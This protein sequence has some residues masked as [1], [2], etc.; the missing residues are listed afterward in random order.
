MEKFAVIMQSDKGQRIIRNN[1]VLKLLPEKLARHFLALLSVQKAGTITDIRSGETLGYL[2]DMPGFLSGLKKKKEGNRRKI[3]RSL[4]QKLKALNVSILCFSDI[5]DYFYEDECLLLEEQGITL[6]DGFLNRVAGLLLVFNRLLIILEKEIPFFETGI[7]GADT[8]LGRLWAEVMASRVNHMCIG[9]RDLQKLERLADYIME[10]TGLSCQT[11]VRPD[12]CF[13]SKN[14][15]VEAETL[16]CLFHAPEPFFHF[17]FYRGESRAANTAGTLYF[18]VETGWMAGPHNIA[19]S[20]KL[21]PWDEPALL[22]GLYYLVSGAYRES[23][24]HRRITLEQIKWVYT[25][26]ENYQIK[27]QGFVHN[28]EKIH[29]DQFRRRY[30]AEI[31]HIS[32]DN[33]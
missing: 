13:S 6:L 11:T 9:G 32:L 1:P 30:F 19:I 25:F 7:W 5:M 33:G 22:D 24:L 8:F 18:P 4:A 16:N 2:L 20:Q 27:P 26:Y 15:L 17:R 28:G 3:I 12:V 29:Y 23:I 10:S 31:S 14:F 21:N